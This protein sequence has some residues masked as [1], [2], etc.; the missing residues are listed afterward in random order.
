MRVLDDRLPDNTVLSHDLIE[1]C[2]LRS[3]VLSDV[4]LVEAWP[5]RYSDDIA[6]R[7]RWIR[8]DWQLAG[9]LRARVPTQGDGREANPLSPLSRW[10]LFDNLRR[11][12]VAP[13]LTATLV[14]CWSR[15]AGPA[16][17]SAAA[18]SVFFLPAFIRI[19][20]TLV[21][22]PHDMPWRQHLGNWAHGAS[23]SLAHAVMSTAFLPHEAWVSLHAIG[24]TGWRMLVTRKHLLQWKASH[25]VRSST[26][27]ESAWRSMWFA[28]LL[29]V[30]VAVLLTFLHPFALFAAA[31]LL[32]L[33]FLSPVLAWWVSLPFERAP[34]DLSQ[35]QTD[36]LAKLARRTWGFFEDVV[37]VQTNWLAPAHLQEQPQPA[38][39]GS[40]SPT[41]IGLALLASRIGLGLRVYFASG[42]AGAA[43]RGLLEHGPA[44]APPRPFLWRL[45]RGHAGAPVPDPH[46]DRRQRQP[47]R[48]LADPGQRAGGTGRR[49]DRQRAFAGRLARHAAR[50]RRTCARRGARRAQSTRRLPRR[51]RSR[52][53]PQRRH[54]AGPG[55]LPGRRR[56]RR[57]PVDCRLA[58]GRRRA[59]A[60]LGRPPGGRLPRLP[61]RSTRPGALDA[62]GA[63]ICAGRQPD[64]H[65][66][67][68][69][70]GRI[71]AAR[72][73]RERG[74]TGAG[75]DGGRGRSHGPGAPGRDRGPGGVRARV[76]RH[77]FRPAAAA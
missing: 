21:D 24:R 52:T 66:D 37:G 53:L 30:V 6:R 61:G 74:R 3:G 48:P 54:P 14:L 27:V 45:R 67:A 42:A 13:T 56:A 49:T 40:T 44:R 22:K 28:P 2:Y 25:L 26:D 62:R 5:A 29:A 8:G 11:S 4:Q 60:R 35:A 47:G 73:R 43:A 63:G 51:A 41:H 1:G 68:A 17:W 34:A 19:L 70:T 65:P 69:R 32:L 38:L 9:W 39:A 10:K 72:T 77:G 33:W 15:L 64:A 59:T 71:A 46:L 57:L 20:V 12:L 16:F 75:A 58:G 31:P 76:R 23:D 50:G 7:H 36:F 18:L 55:R